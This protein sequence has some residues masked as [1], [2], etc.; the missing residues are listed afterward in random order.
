ME[1]IRSSGE[2]NAGGIA[3]LGKAL[4]LIQR[5]GMDI[6]RE[7][8]QA[9]TKRTV[10]GMMQIN[11]LDIYGIRSPESPRFTNKI[12]VI[13]FNLKNKMSNTVAKELAEKGGIGVRYG[14]HCA[15]ILIKHLLKVSP[16]LERFQKLIVTLFPVLKLP[17]VVRISLGIENSIEDI[18]TLIEVLVNIASKPA[19]R[20]GRDPVSSE[21]TNSRLSESEV[22]K[23]MQIL[24]KAAVQKVYT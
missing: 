15:H 23:Q 9:L 20:S 3:A 11:G 6:I 16:S 22:Q 13:S 8:E 24:I 2:E 17:G 5:I 4:L 18:D 14:C 10:L 21:S 7:E 12:G 19:L 1:L